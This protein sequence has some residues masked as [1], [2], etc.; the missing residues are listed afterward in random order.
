MVLVFVSTFPKGWTSYDDETRTTYM[1]L[2]QLVMRVY[3]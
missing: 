2:Q 3:T 1:L